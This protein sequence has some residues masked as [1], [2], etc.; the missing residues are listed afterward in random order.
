MKVDC[1]AEDLYAFEPI[2]E[3][4]KGFATR[5]CDFSKIAHPLTQRPSES[6]KYSHYDYQLI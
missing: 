4:E 6:G 2:N 5:I 1:W 3:K